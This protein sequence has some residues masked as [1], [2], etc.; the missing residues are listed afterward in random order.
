MSFSSS[1]SSSALS[2]SLS[3]SPF[4]YSCIR[5]LNLLPFCVNSFIEH[6]ETGASIRNYIASRTSTSLASPIAPSFHAPPAGARPSESVATTTS[7][8]SSSSVVNDPLSDQLVS[9]FNQCVDDLTAFRTSHIN[10]VA[11]YV[12]AQ[13]RVVEKKAQEAAA[14]AGGV[15]ATK[16]SQTHFYAPVGPAA[17]TLNTPTPSSSSSTTMNGNLF[18][19]ANHANHAGHGHAHG[20]GTN[21]LNGVNGTSNGEHKSPEPDN[22]ARPLAEVSQPLSME[23]IEV[24]TGGSSIMPLLKAVRDATSDGAI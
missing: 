8:S 23:R 4:C 11:T 16:K 15:L 20:N 19:H 14:S 17:V 10:I 7:S 18:A 3:L 9:I 12:I 22:V 21:G 6:L 5:R 13:G 1:S 24:G 2:L